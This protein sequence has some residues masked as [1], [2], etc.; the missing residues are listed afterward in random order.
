MVD[1]VTIS[2]RKNGYSVFHSVQ[3]GPGTSQAFFLSNIFAGEI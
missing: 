3:I 2:G 1:Q